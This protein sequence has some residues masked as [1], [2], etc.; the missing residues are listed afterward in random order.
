[1]ADLYELLITA[2]LPADL[3]EAELAELR[4]HLG[5][6]PEPAQFTIVT[7]YPIDYVGDGDPAHDRADDSWEVQR[8]PLLAR[9]GPADARVGGL[10]FSGLA[11]RQGRHPG[12]VFTSRQ[13]IHGPTQWDMVIEMI[14][15]LERKVVAPAGH[16]GLSIHLRHC[17]DTV[18]KPA[19]LV[20]DR[21]VSREDPSRSL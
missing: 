4:W 16:E 3:P 21:I 17:E 11:L 5:L 13:E 10:N 1:V 19:A 9:H 14:R 8:E 6:G 12:W 18:L 2:E 20:G 7:D 15:W